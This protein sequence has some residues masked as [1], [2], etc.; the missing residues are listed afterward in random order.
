MEGQGVSC[1]GQRFCWTAQ[2]NS[3]D[4]T[5]I[6][7]VAKMEL[8][9][10]LCMPLQI[11][12]FT[13]ILHRSSPSTSRITSNIFLRSSQAWSTVGMGTATLSPILI[14]WRSAI[15]LLTTHSTWASKL[16]VALHLP[17]LTPTMLHC[18][19]ALPWNDSSS[20][21]VCFCFGLLIVNFIRLIVSLS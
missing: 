13:A 17:L 21:T 18:S 8:V 6:I 4:N 10:W 9:P 5:D 19:K 3:A 15:A 11:T 1:V 14:D 20:H 7:Y 16:H 12:L 2:C